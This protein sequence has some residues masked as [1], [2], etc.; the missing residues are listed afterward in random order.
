M[1][2][3]FIVERKRKRGGREGRE[4]GEPRQWDINQGITVYY[5]YFFFLPRIY[6]SRVLGR[7]GGGVRYAF[8]VHFFSPQMR[9]FVVGPQRG[10]LYLNFWF[11]GVFFCLFCSFSL[12]KVDKRG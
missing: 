12:K 11:E 2:M 6:Y 7:G 9:F 1:F 8:Y 3:K 5:Y 10:P 4:K